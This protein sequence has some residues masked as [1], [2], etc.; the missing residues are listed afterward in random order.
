MAKLEGPRLDTVAY[1][2][3]C[4]IVDLGGCATHAQLLDMLSAD[5]RKQSTFKR[6]VTD[7]LLRYEVVTLDNDHL[8]LRATQHGKEYIG[9]QIKVEPPAKYEGQIAPARIRTF[10]EFNVQKHRAVAPQRPGADDYK[11]IP[12][13]YTAAVVK[14]A[15]VNE[16]GAIIRTTTVGHVIRKLPDGKVVA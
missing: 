10:C 15:E 8:T 1:R 11:Q 6:Y 5:Y 16:H 3:L 9:A 2:V 14:Q 7:V 13:L 12:S 4:R